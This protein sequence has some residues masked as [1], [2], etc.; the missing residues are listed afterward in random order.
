MFRTRKGFTLIELLVVIAIIAILAAILFPV[1]AQAREKARQ[2][3]C[4]NNLKQMGLAHKLYLDDYDGVF[5]PNVGYNP[6]GMS[7][8]GVKTWTDAL[9][10]YNKSLDTYTCP[11]DNHT[12][13]YSRNTY[14]GGYSPPSSL[15]QESDIAEPVR[16]L[17]IFECPGAGIKKAQWGV[18]NSNDTGDADLDNA[19]QNDGN[20]YGGGK[21]MT[22]IPIYRHGDPDGG[23]CN[24]HWL[25]WPGRHSNGNVLLFL[26]GHVKWFKDWDANQMTFDPL[27]KWGATTKS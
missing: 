23:L 9:K 10:M 18:K 4:S 14:E 19:G 20:V 27:K 17:D 1:F 25:Y 24:W 2:S 16:F 22:N 12:F 7:S 8:G 11:S 15:Y 5:M 3:S 13:S 6:L 26:D 21:K